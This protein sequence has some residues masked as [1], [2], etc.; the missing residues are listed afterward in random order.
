MRVRICMCDL[1]TCG[2][3]SLGLQ[4]R[5]RLDVYIPGTPVWVVKC[6]LYNACAFA[7]GLS[8]NSPTNGVFMCAG[9][10]GCMYAHAAYAYAYILIFSFFSLSASDGTCLPPCVHS[11]CTCAR[12]AYVRSERSS[13]AA[14]SAT[15]VSFFISNY[16]TTICCYYF[17]RTHAHI[18]TRT[19]ANTHS[20]PLSKCLYYFLYHVFIILFISPD[21]NGLFIDFSINK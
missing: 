3:F 20:L 1:F 10:Y 21:A 2:V 4:H 18:L 7:C 11:T 9:M 12:V 14:P 17:L 13:R 15:Y 6:A 5:Q 16:S 19:H 8:V